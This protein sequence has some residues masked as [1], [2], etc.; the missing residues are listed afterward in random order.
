MSTV[1]STKKLTPSQKQLLLNSGLSFVEYDAIK[2][3]L[4]PFN[5]DLKS[6]DN[7]IITSRNAVRSILKENNQ[8]HLPEI[9]FFCVGEKTEKLLLSKGL[10]V[11][12]TCDYGVDL[13]KL[14]AHKYKND[15]FTYLCGN[16]RREELPTILKDHQVPLR[17]VE[18][19]NTSLNKKVFLQD[20]EAVLFFSPSGIQSFCSVND[21]KRTNAIC[22]GKSTAFEAKKHTENIITA[23]KPSVENV[24]VQAVKHFGKNSFGTKAENI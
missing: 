12:E 2:I 16:V 13:A 3:D 7:C 20:F 10:R 4:L 19:Y 15:S 1:L 24:I 9:N 8:R 6:G 18:V 17:E 5:L 22:I 21:L 23:T 14:L 11:L